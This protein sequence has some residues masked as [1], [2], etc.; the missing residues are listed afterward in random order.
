MYIINFQTICFYI[1]Q[2]N[3]YWYKIYKLQI[4]QLFR[5]LN[6]T[7]QMAT[8]WCISLGEAQQRLPKRL[9]KHNI[10]SITKRS[11]FTQQFY[12]SSSS[13]CYST[14][15]NVLLKVSTLQCHVKLQ[16]EQSVTQILTKY[17][18]KYSGSFLNRTSLLQHYYYITVKEILS[19][20]HEP[21]GQS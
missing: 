10:S 21:R 14:S 17:H 12:C 20:P 1:T 16:T 8:D 11:K 13:S 19:K 18:N 2:P 15:F 5:K 4:L 7:R 6:V 9:Y 3:Q